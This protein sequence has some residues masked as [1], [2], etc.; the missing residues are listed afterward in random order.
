M[1]R[2]VKTIPDSPLVFMSFYVFKNMIPE[3]KKTW[4]RKRKSLVTAG[5]TWLVSLHWSSGLKVRNPMSGRLLGI[6]FL[7]TTDPR[8]GWIPV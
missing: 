5:N 7:S 1:E 4:R 6:R 2:Y 8:D 3:D